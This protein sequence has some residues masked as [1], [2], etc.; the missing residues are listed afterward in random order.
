MNIARRER[1]DVL[2][3]LLMDFGEWRSLRRNRGAKSPAHFIRDRLPNWAL[4]Y[5]PGVMENVVE[6]PVSLGAKSFPI[7]RVKR[8]R[9][10]LIGL[11]G[12]FLNAHSER[13]LR[14]ALFHTCNLAAT[15]GFKELSWIRIY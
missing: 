1:Q 15:Q 8:L 12:Q 6:H 13:T 4:P 10:R 2:H 9:L 7:G 3:E 14:I 11:A 5:V